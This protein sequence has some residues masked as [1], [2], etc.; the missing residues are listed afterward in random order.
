M[1]GACFSKIMIWLHK[2]QVRSVYN[3]TIQYNYKDVTDNS[4][5]NEAT[6]APD[7]L[8]LTENVCAV[9]A[10]DSSTDTIQFV[11]IT[12]KFASSENVIDHHT[13][14]DGT[15]YMIGHFLENGYYQITRKKYKLIHKS[16]SN[17]H[18]RISCIILRK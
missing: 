16:E 12:V 17:F 4:E 18:Q 14:S 15:K 10:D 13:V 3:Q 11:Q 9:A 2:I 8:H 1:V 5:K 6:N 7:D